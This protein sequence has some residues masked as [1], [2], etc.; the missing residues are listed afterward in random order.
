MMLLMLLAGCGF[1]LRGKV[2]VPPELKQV[3]LDASGEFSPLTLEL[4]RVLQRSGTQVLTN[5]KE[6]EA[7][8]RILG[9]QTNRRVLSVDAQGRAAEYEL[10]YRIQFQIENQAGEVMMPLQ[11]INLQR[12]YRFDPGAVLAKDAE[13]AQIQREMVSAGVRQMMRRIDSHF[14]ARAKV[15]HPQ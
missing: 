4:K 3:Y 13:E 1:Q 9:E 6:A 5:R 10:D 7:I 12:D 14:K 15:A 2:D 11:K 8:I